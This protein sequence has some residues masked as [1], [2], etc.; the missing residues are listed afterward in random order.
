ML[1]LVDIV[2]INQVKVHIYIYIYQTGQSSTKTKIKECL[3]DQFEV[4]HNCYL[5]ILKVAVK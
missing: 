2:N 3:Q 1:D 4:V 5:T